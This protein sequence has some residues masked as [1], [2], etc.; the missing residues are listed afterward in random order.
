MITRY[1]MFS[2]NLDN[3]AYDDEVTENYFW[4]HYDDY[5]ISHLLEFT[6]EDW[7]RLL[8]E[9]PDQSIMW[10]KRLCQ[11]LWDP[12]PQNPPTPCIKAWLSMANT[13]DVE[14]FCW[15]VESLL[16]M[17]AF[18]VEELKPIYVEAKKTV[19]TAENGFKKVLSEFVNK[20]EMA[21]NRSMNQ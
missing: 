9:L 19:L 1:D 11:C 13:E 8:A 6:D 16:E 4:D 20:Y 3:V 5:Y 17:N 15:I 18:N 7:N 21:Q 12:D 14:L 2:H 10:K